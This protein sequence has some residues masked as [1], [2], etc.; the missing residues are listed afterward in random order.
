[1]T[2]R[3]GSWCILL[4][5]LALATTSIAA[6][7]AANNQAVF[8]L[9]VLAYDRNLRSRAGDTVNIAVVFRDG[10]D[11]SVGAK[12]D[13]LSGLDKLGDVRVSDL[14]FRA[15]PVPFTSPGDL[16]NVI[17]STRAAAVYV[18]PGLEGSVG[19]ITDVT[20]RRSALTFSGV[21]SMVR[22]SLSVGL[23]ARSGKPAILVNLAASKAEGADLDPALL[24]L[25][26]VL[27]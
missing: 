26:E 12:N 9:R 13:L 2:R 7:L 24:R 27:R 5:G 6:D 18:C 20:R 23:V 16:D 4:M 11:M 10:N 22:A 3:L 1:V 8:L 25:A 17:G 14:P 19:P 15:T 21:E